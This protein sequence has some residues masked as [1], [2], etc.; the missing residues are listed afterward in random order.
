MNRLQDVNR[1][2]QKRE[3]ER[4]WEAGQLS[5]AADF[6]MRPNMRCGMPELQRTAPMSPRIAVT[7]SQT[8]SKYRFPATPAPFS[9]SINELR[10]IKPVGKKGSMRWL[11]VHFE[12]R[13]SFAH[14]ASKMAARGRQSA[15]GLTML[16]NKT[17]GVDPRIMREYKH[18]TQPRYRRSLQQSPGRFLIE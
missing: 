8:V 6:A 2:K 12:A 9:V 7:S 5:D 16:G 3:S 4:K 18:L 14:H 15:A 1:N 13:L 10:V 17:R 11:G